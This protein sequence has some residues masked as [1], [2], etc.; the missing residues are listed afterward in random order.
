MARSVDCPEG[1]SLVE[2]AAPMA[3]FASVES[4][5]TTTTGVSVSDWQD[6]PHYVPW[7]M[8]SLPGLSVRPNQC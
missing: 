5:K 2:V 8:L 4:N 6:E 7:I 3:Q 1:D